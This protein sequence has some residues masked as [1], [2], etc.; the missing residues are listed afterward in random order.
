M[1]PA[2]LALI[3]LCVEMFVAPPAAGGQTPVPDLAQAERCGP[4]PMKP[5]SCLNGGW[6]CRCRASGQVCEWELIGCGPSEGLAPRPDD[7]RSQTPAP[8]D[9][10]R[11]GLYG[12]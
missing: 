11:P 8:G 10:A 1:K 9:P 3:L 2:T 6:V 7:R 5:A 12:R 4:R